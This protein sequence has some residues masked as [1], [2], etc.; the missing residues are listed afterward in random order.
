MIK[1]GK[2]YAK[3]V[4]E[5]YSEVMDGLKLNIEELQAVLADLVHWWEQTLKVNN[6]DD[7]Q[8]QLAGI[9]AGFLIGK[10]K[11][12]WDILANIQLLCNDFVGFL[13]KE[14]HNKKP[15]K[16]GK[17]ANWREFIITSEGY[18]E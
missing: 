4:S 2:Y 12:E 14:S 17:L 18:E 11:L 3:E 16:L 5:T 7:S 13:L 9:I 1:I 15:V 10:G 6:L 8:I